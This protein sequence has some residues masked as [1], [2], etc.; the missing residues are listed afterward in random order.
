MAGLLNGYP[1]APLPNAN[2]Y[3]SYPI[4]DNNREWSAVSGDWTGVTSTMASVNSPTQLRWQPYGAGP[5]TAHIVWTSQVKEGGL[6]GGAYGS[7]SYVDGQNTVIVMDGMA[8]TNIP[9]TTPFG[10]LFGQF[11]CWSLATGKLLYIANGTITCGIHLPNLLG[12]F[13]Q[14][15]NIGAAMGGQ[16]TLESSYG[17]YVYPYL[18]GTVTV[19]GVVYWNYYDALS[20]ILKYQYTNCGS[21]RLIDGTILAFGTQSLT[22]TTCTAL[23]GYVYRWNMTSVLNNN[24]TTGVTWKHSS[25]TNYRWYSKR[26]GNRN[27]QYLPR[28]NNVCS[29]IRSLRVCDRNTYETYNAY[30]A[31][32][33]ASIWNLTLNYQTNTNEEL[34]L[35]QVN[36]FIV[37]NPTA[38]DF[39]CY[40]IMTGALL[41]TTP[42]VANSPWATTWTIYYTETNDLSNVYI[43]Y[44]DGTM[45]AY[46]LATGDLIWT[47]TPFASTEYPNNAIPYVC[48]G[49][50]YEGGLI[51]TYAGYS[52]SYQIDP[53]PRFAMLVAINAT[54]GDIAWTLNGG[55]MPSAA[56]DGYILGSSQFDGMLYTLSKGQTTTTVTAPTLSITAGTTALIQGSVMDNSPAQPNTP[57]I[58]D[59]NMSV[60]MDYL[61]MQN[62]T[63]LNAPPNC[64]GVPVTLNSDQQH[65]HN[66]QLRHRYKRQRRTLR[67]SMD[68]N[69]RRIIHRLRNICRNQRIL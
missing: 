28:P 57:A 18:W 45:S 17:S 27:S 32:T 65:R 44:P 53:V 37:W 24:W 46:S 1:W 56:A 67:N 47:S 55:V 9:N 5:E 49:T 54:T 39:N 13:Q 38:S 14:S 63:L 62:A 12:A 20:G 4:N 15:T 22:S 30:N 26:S 16:V 25:Y 42:S 29:I 3:W 68:P 33:G 6:I 35:A 10:Q 61:H 41:W 51:Y 40:S 23:N 36:D 52:T 8:Y 34:Q 66:S 31:L 69:N 64:I 19:N 58:S 2:V 59:A 7:T 11:E 48:T 50:V 60:W 43:A 21:A